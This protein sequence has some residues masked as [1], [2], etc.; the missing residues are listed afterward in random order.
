MNKITILYDVVNKMDWQVM[1]VNKKKVTLWRGLDNSI[2]G[3]HDLIP[4]LPIESIEYES[5]DFQKEW[6]ND[7][8]PDV[9]LTNHD[10]MCTN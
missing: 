9:I 2:V 5:R 4:Y 3:I 10:F 1:Y 6:E 8:P 7:V